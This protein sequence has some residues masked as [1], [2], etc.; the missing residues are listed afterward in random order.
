MARCQGQLTAHVWFI[1]PQGFDEDWAKTDLWYTAAAVPGVQVHLDH[2]EKVA[3]LF[4]AMTSGQALLYHEGG[5]LLFQGGITPA[6]GHAGDNPGSAAIAALV[7]HRTHNFASTPV[8]GCA[9][10]RDQKAKECTTC[11]P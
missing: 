8:F 9:L 3:R 6:R 7:K 10:N 11:Q 2:Q 4:H 5:T 1:Q